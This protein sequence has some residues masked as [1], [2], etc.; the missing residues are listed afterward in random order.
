LLRLS[1][2]SSG[3]ILVAGADLRG[4]GERAWRAQIASCCN[5]VATAAGCVAV[6]AADR[7][8]TTNT[9]SWPIQ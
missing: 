1:A 7:R 5:D 2:P 6:A 9:L 8:L 4:G 3:E